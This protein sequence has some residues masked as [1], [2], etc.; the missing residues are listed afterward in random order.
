[1]TVPQKHHYVLIY[2]CVCMSLPEYVLTLS[3]S[4]LWTCGWKI[5]FLFCLYLCPYLYSYDDDDG[6]VR[7]GCYGG[8]DDG[9]LSCDGC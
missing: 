9:D 2:L 4:Q 8:G 5:W 6:G 1:M 7:C 3:L